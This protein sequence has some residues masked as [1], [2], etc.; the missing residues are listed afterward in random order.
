MNVLVWILVSVGYSGA[1]NMT[2]SPP[3]VSLESCEAL[4][5]TFED[6]VRRA[7]CVQ[8]KVYQK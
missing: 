1:A 2:Y 7:Q 8:I 4:R 5:K 3:L 6:T